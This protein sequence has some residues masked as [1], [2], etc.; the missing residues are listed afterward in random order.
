VRPW[1]RENHAHGGE[2]HQRALRH[3]TDPLKL[4]ISSTPC[5]SPDSTS[6]GLTD[7]YEASGL[8]VVMQR[9]SAPRRG[10]AHDARAGAS[11]PADA[12]G[13]RLSH[14]EDA[15]ARARAARSGSSRDVKNC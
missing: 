3:P 13:L 5:S 14:G 12:R 8:P 1:R 9:K 4:V 11:P 15:A 7:G 10:R 2:R 6:T